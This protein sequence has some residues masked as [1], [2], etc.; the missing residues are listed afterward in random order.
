MSIRKLISVLN[1]RKGTIVTGD[2]FIGRDYLVQDM[3][4]YFYCSALG[5]NIAVNGLPRVG[6]TSL[7]RHSARES[8][9]QED[10]NPMTIIVYIDMGS[11]FLNRDI[12]FIYRTLA[13]KILEKIS[14]AQRGHNIL[15]DD[16]YAEIA[17]Y[18]N[19][20][21]KYGEARFHLEHLLQDV[22]RKGLIVRLVLD[23]FD[24]ILTICSPGNTLNCEM[25][26][27]FY[28]FLRTIITD[29]ENYSMKVALISRNKLSEIEPPGVESK[30]S[31]VC[32]SL[33]LIPFKSKEMKKYWE[34]LRQWD[35]E[36]IITEEYVDDIE[37]FAGHMPYWLDVANATMLR[38]QSHDMDR[39]ELEDEMFRVMRDEYH[40][41]L[42]MMGDSRYLNKEMSSDYQKKDSLRSKL[43][44]LMVGPR[45]NLNNS[46][47]MLLIGYAVVKR[48]GQD[49]SYESLSKV[50]EDY[51]Q[52][53]PNE[54]PVWD[55]IFMLE[56]KMRRLIKDV[57]IANYS[58]DW[59][60]DFSTKFGS[61]DKGFIARL[62]KDREKSMRLFGDGASSHLLDYLYMSDYFRYFIKDNWNS[63]FKKVFS[64]YHGDINLLQQHMS[65]LCDVRNPL[66]HSNGAF[67]T[68]ADIV[69][70]EDYCNNICAQIDE[71]L[72]SM[73]GL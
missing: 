9:A 12:P 45:Y 26:N 2:D 11:E 3:I 66:A 59:E 51:L 19:N 25:L 14:T 4:D 31:G 8:V 67:L 63:Y 29:N 49:G 58:G 47:V 64:A 73:T 69:R 62:K 34:Y 7:L 30:L 18:E 24:H 50:F 16:D 5:K 41:V 56:Q 68:K 35:D 46:D 37:R 42:K 21:A 48:S 55:S 22:K 17:E 54:T 1:A 20:H 61:N 23:E 13:T 40:H 65:F 44:Q 33:T 60:Q 32:E 43:L 57:Y 70:A 38:G 28:L 15:A 36:N 52:F 6:K 53:V 72:N 10:F 27:G 71:Y 39:D